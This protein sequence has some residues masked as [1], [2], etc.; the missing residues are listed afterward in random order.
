MWKETSCVE[1]RSRRVDEVFDRRRVS[2]RS[3]FFLCL[4]ISQLRLVAQ[5]KERFTTVGGCPPL[6]DIEDLIEIQVGSLPRSRR[7]G[8]RAVVTD[9]AAQLG[10]GDEHLSRV[11]HR[12]PEPCIPQ[13]RRLFHECLEVGLVGKLQRVV[14]RGQSGCLVFH[15]PELR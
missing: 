3:Q 10:E 13:R 11:G 15:G 9:V 12:S 4:L 8:E 1:H 14:A 2:Q 6:G 7:L 5:R